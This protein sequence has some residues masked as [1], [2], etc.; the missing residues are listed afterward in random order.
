MCKE[1]VVKAV[2]GVKKRKRAKWL[3]L[4][5][6]MR[7]K[8]DVQRTDEKKETDFYGRMYRSTEK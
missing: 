6:Q 4:R 7:E 1:V 8:N 5:K 3:T 2:V